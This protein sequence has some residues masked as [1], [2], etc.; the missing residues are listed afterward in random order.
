M[1]FVVFRFSIFP[2]IWK[3]T[4]KHYFSCFVSVWKYEIQNKYL[5]N[6]GNVLNFHYYYL[7][8]KR[9]SVHYFDFRFFYLLR[10]RNGTLCIRL[11]MGWCIKSRT[12]LSVYLSPNV[13]ISNKH[14]QNMSYKAE[15]WHALSH[16]QYFLKFRFQISYDVPLIYIKKWQWIIYTF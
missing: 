12:C 10:E 2:K 1:R 8:Y 6:L 11:H 4:I 16:E 9:K 15:N 14:C 5:L 13:R 3:R 7:C